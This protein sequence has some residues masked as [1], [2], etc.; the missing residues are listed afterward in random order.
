MSR[1]KGDAAEGRRRV[2]PRYVHH[3]PEL[4]DGW[5]S[6]V[7]TP[8]LR[9]PSRRRSK[10]VSAATAVTGRGSLAGCSA[11]AARAISITP[12]AVS[13]AAAVEGAGTFNAG[14]GSARRVSCDVSIDADCCSPWTAA[15][16]DARAICSTL[17]AVSPA[18][19]GGRARDAGVAAGSKS[20]LA[21][22][23]LPTTPPGNVTGNS[24]VTMTPQALD[25]VSVSVGTRGAR[26]VVLM[27]R[28]AL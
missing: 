23:L 14:G 26:H 19:G 22:R 5:R 20:M 12:S 17:S 15:I 10:G 9:L 4:I 2:V 8:C 6:P 13:P 18:G 16:A 28:E 27:I 7:D 11:T 21:R 3:R 25:K 1:D 24:V